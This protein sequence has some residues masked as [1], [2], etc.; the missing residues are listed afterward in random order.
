MTII[1]MSVSNGKI[2]FP[3]LQEGEIVT[4]YGIKVKVVPTP[5]NK[6]NDCNECEIHHLCN[7][8]YTKLKELCKMRGVDCCGQLIGIRRHFKIIK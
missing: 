3:A 5:N 2:K 7:R 8:D 4:V 1:V 6:N